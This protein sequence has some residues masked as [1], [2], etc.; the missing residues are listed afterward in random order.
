MYA[1]SESVL[2]FMHINERSITYIHL[3]ENVKVFVN[4]LLKTFNPTISLLGNY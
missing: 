3:E 1:N 2:I 4:D